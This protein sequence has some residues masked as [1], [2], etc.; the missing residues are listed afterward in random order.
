VSA[1]TIGRSANAQHEHGERQKGQKELN[2]L[3]IDL[4]GEHGELS[5]FGIHKNYPLLV[6]I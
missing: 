1:T 5:K 6:C 4:A 3:A 2:M